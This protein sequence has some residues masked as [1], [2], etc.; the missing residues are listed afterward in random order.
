MCL[1]LSNLLLSLSLT[2]LSFPYIADVITLSD[3]ISKIHGTSSKIVH[4]CAADTKV[5]IPV[6][7]QLLL[8]S[9]TLHLLLLL[10]QTH[11]NTAFFIHH[12]NLA[13][14]MVVV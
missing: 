10:Q 8:L 2:P 7:P 9:L 3:V 1:L 4:R 12:Y 14:K 13:A 5:V 6:S 11:F